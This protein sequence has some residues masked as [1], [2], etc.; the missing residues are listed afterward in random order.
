MKVQLVTFGG[1]PNADATRQALRRNMSVAGLEPIFE[2][3]DSTARETP[4]LLRDWGSP[5]VL[6]DGV[7]VGGHEKPTGRSCRLYRD[8]VGGMH[9][10]PPESLLLAAIRA[11]RG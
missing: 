7:D 6:I 11:A 3:I 2:E 10:S 9:G 4:E 1:C 5:T 8:G